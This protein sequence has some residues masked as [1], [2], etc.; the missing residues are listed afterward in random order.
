MKIKL[1]QLRTLCVM[2]FLCLYTATAEA[3]I[4][5]AMPHSVLVAAA[6]VAVQATNVMNTT[7]G[8]QWT[9]VPGATSYRLDVSTTPFGQGNDNDF[10][11][12]NLFVENVTYYT[13]TGLNPATP[14]YYRVR[15]IDADGA[16]QNSNTIGLL[17]TD[18][19]TW[20][21]I[22]WTDSA[23]TAGINAFVSGNYNTA[24]NGSFT[25]KNL[26]VTNDGSLTVASGTNITV[27]STITNNAAAS[28]FTIENNANLL[29]IAAV[30]TNAGA[31]TIDRN[32]LMRRLDY[33]YWSSPVAGQNLHDFSPET[34]ANRFYT[35]TEAGNN[36]TAVDP[37]VNNF[38]LA[39]GYV[40]RAPDVYANTPQSFNGHF[41]GTPHN[42]N[43]SI[44]V[45]LDGQGY[46]LIGNPYPS[47][48]NAASFLNANPGINT[49]Y[50]WTHTVQ[51]SAPGANYATINATGETAA[52]STTPESDTPNGTIQVG[53]GFVA[54]VNTAGNAVFNNNMR[55][56][57]NADQ[58]FRTAA[59]ERD[60]L[61]VGLTGEGA[62]RSE[63]LIGYV[64]GATNGVD[65]QFDAKQL[66]LE[67]TRLYSL[68]DTETPYVIQGKT[69]PFTDTD[70]V[71]LGFIAGQAGNYTIALGRLEGVFEGTQDIFL[72][73]N[74]TGT[75]TNLKSGG[76]NFFS[77]AGTFTN[78][79]TLLYTSNN[80]GMAVPVTTENKIIA[81]RNNARI[82]IRSSEVA[83]TEV[84][85]YDTA[86][87]L[88]YYTN[89]ADG[90]KVRVP[91]LDASGALLLLRIGTADGHQVSKK[92][93]F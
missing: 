19:T 89:Q 17:T 39:K 13:V 51:G 88:L 23:P 58:F 84:S 56:A 49:I 12:E 20:D 31:I 53:Q 62:A 45:T 4:R 29:Q 36:F 30:N 50:F 3:E 68:I 18:E 44:P 46:N 75:I 78:R 93:I 82:E 6:P 38:S 81:F 87:R 33:V 37:Y 27:V 57:N 1:L 34:L 52:S 10:V 86:G 90:N 11:F 77:E 15:A 7:F 32:A 91:G 71:R 40:I 14:Y 21:G 5:S 28:S 42:G 69:S 80:L 85:V 47:T 64:E 74:Q 67:G 48:I 63:I 76:C 22:G 26:T 2:A 55:V 16:S 73:D 25:S 9:V 79:F 24:P 83:I 66:L 92:M 43:L 8:A 35:I 70:S 54:Y 41:T 72:K 59:S 60:R 61:W 65:N